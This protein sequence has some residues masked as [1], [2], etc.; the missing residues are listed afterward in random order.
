MPFDSFSVYLLTYITVPVDA[1]LLQRVS[2]F[3]DLV[4]IQVG[5]AVLQRVCIFA[6]LV[7]IPAGAAVLQLLV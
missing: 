6:D 2:I 3:A 5:E 7:P 4:P 1:A